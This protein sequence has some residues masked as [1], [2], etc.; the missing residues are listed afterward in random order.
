MELVARS[1]QGTMLSL[2]LLVFLLG[3]QPDTPVIDTAF[4]QVAPVSRDEDSLRKT[5]GQNRAIVLIQGMCPHPF[6][7]D[8]VARAEWQGWQRPES[9][10]VE[11]LGKEGDVFAFAY[12]QN[13]PI[14][15]VADGAKL[16]GRVIHLKKLGY[17]EIVLVGHSA[18]GLVARHLVEDHPDAGVTKVIQVC[19]PNGGS[20][21]GNF[22]VGVR[23]DQEPFVRSL[24]HEGR[25]ACL[26]HRSDKKI[27]AHIDFVCVV[28]HLT[29]PFRPG[30][31]VVY[32]DCQW[33][34][35]LRQQCIPAVPLR[36]DHQS[37]VRG[38][39]FA[40][41]LAELVREKQPRWDAEKIRLE[42][43]RL[44]DR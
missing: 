43:S 31:G 39:A 34:D 37:I 36:V 25:Q 10:L 24:S 41:K 11:T 35:D 21:W 38:K 23:R 20:L 44:F 29:G 7:N 4:A 33:T 19:S 13:R 42:K 17:T 14:E 5:P 26:K 28:G 8:R 6:R 40:P 22:T 9:H 12:G 18:G 15:E 3:P 30:D 2:T 27:P 1:G 32:S 16:V